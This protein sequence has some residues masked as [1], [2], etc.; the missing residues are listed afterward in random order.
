V[1]K[2]SMKISHR[3]VVDLTDPERRSRFAAIG[4]DVHP[5]DF[6]FEVTE[7]D[8]RWPAIE[9]FVRD[10][11]LLDIVSTSFSSEER[12]RALSLVML[13]DGHWEY[14]MP[15]DDFGYLNQTY[16]P[17]NACFECGIGIEQVAPFR[18][19]KVPKWGRRSFIQLNW[20]FDEFFTPPEVWQRVFEPLG[21]PCRPVVLH[22]TGAVV[23]SIVQLDIQSRVDIP[24][25]G[26]PSEVCPRCGLVKSN[27]VKRGYW[28][29]PWG[30]EAPLRK[31]RQWFGSGGS[32][33]RPVIASSEIYHR[34]QELGL[35]GVSF[36]PCAK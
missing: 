11:G 30:D 9:A 19:R 22:K 7:D 34:I 29:E 24:V 21:V 15:D 20:V 32:A 17:S 36:T 13:A 10:Y 2:N 14:P 23:D 28:P 25:E 33:Y 5:G 18:I 6:A 8:S 1:K 31:T 27:F 12:Q 3:I 35:R 26:L 4:F 16:D